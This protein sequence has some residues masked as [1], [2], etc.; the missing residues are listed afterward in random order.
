MSEKISILG[1]FFKKWTVTYFYL[2][3]ELANVFCKE[4]GSKYFWLF[5][6]CA[7]YPTLFTKTAGRY[8]TRYL[9]P[10]YIKNLYLNNKKTNNLI[11]GKRSE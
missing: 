9:Y 1:V 7:L 5:S 3:Q 2:K 4:S 11:I 6:P 8:L 10:A